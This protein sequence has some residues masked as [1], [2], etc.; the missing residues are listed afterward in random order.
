MKYSVFAIAASLLLGS[1]TTMLNTQTV[2]TMDIYGPGVMHH[3]VIADLEVSNTKVSAS[4]NGLSTEI[5]ALKGE[6][7]NSAVKSSGADLLVEPVY[8]VTHKGG[9]STVL[10]TGFPASYKNFRSATQADLP[11]LEA[12]IL[13]RAQK[14]EVTSTAA[15]KNSPAAAIVGV[16]LVLGILAAVVAGP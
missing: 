7:V 12:G 4:V 5:S 8:E 15:K 10:V 14:A 9:R 16:V 6:A 3:P 11:M 2:K 1:C 13:H